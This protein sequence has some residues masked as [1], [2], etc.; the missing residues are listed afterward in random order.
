VSISYALG[1]ILGGAFSPMIAT[2]L[3]QATGG[4][5]A[6]GVYLL[7]M[8]L[9]AIAAVLMLCERR[10][11]DLGIGN[12]AQQEVG[13]TVFDRRRILTAAEHGS[14]IPSVGPK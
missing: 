11:I 8:T 7:V 6:V 2:A 12:Q 4:T 3:V 1:A 5:T 13:S 14:Q 10:G 9:L